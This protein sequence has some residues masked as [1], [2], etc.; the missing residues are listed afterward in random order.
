MLRLKVWE[1]FK[2]QVLENCGR[3]HTH[4][5]IGGVPQP[6]KSQRGRRSLDGPTLPTQPEFR[7]RKKMLTRGEAPGEERI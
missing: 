3:L 1:L 7:G 2:L 6:T 4:V 5:Q